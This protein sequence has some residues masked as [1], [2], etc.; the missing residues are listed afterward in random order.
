[1]LKHS[2]NLVKSSYKGQSNR[3]SKVL[4]FQTTVTA[5]IAV[6]E[7][8]DKKQWQT[9]PIH[10]LWNIFPVIKLK[11]QTIYIQQTHISRKK[12]KHQLQHLLCVVGPI[13]DLWRMCRES[14]RKAA[15]SRVIWWAQQGSWTVTRVS[16]GCRVTDY[17]TSV[18]HSKMLYYYYIMLGFIIT[19]LYLFVLALL[20]EVGTDMKGL[21][22]WM[23]SALKPSRWN[24][25]V[26]YCFHDPVHSFWMENKTKQTNKYTFPSCKV[27]CFLFVQKWYEDG[28]V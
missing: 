27:C 19:L 3:C 24:L 1:M 2:Q 8:S 11:K 10:T 6:I 4:C 14:R 9:F 13:S 20:L 25:A 18:F 21:M 7:R 16:E 28:I 12:G 26:H 15:F 23:W 22:M 5:L 17:C